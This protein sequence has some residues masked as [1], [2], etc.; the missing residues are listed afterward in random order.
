MVYALSICANT[1]LGDIPAN[2]AH[3]TQLIREAAKE[4]SLD[5]VVMSEV[6]TTGF[7]DQHMQQYAETPEGPSF[8]AFHALSEEI[9]ALVGWGYVEA[10]PNGKP[11]NSFAL[12][13]GNELLGIC[14]KTHLSPINEGGPAHA[15]EPGTFDPGDELC[16]LDT[17][18]GK[19]GIM[20][21]M[22]GCFPEVS[23]TLCLRGA[24]LLIWSSRSWG[25]QADMN[26]P[27]QRA[28]ECV[29]PL[30]HCD[31]WQY[32]EGFED[33]RGHA[34]I[35]SHYGKVLAS[36]ESPSEVMGAELNLQEAS[37]ARNYGGGPLQWKNLRR[38][39]LYTSGL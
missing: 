10:N 33:S 2:V 23:R 31:G 36:C 16:L 35:A 4:R 21:C 28:Y 14:R 5:L 6:A 29:T 12:V 24:D 32:C 20:I 30:I 22:D 17:R 15:D 18:L 38:P 3:Y 9:G 1:V 19:I 26:T 13:D 37:D 25:S 27:A 11:F 39:D 7:I 8:Q 34:Q